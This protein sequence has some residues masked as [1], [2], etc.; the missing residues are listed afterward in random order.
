[1]S[2]IEVAVRVMGWVKQ[3]LEARTVVVRHLETGV[4]TSW[5]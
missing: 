2:V 3:M 5:V 1:M 4:T